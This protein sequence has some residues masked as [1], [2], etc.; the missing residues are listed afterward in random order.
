MFNCSTN[1][2]LVRVDVNRP[3]TSRLWL[4]RDPIGEREGV[5]LFSFVENCPISRE[6][7]FGLQSIGGTPPDPGRNCR[8]NCLNALTTCL[9]NLSSYWNSALKL[10]I[11]CLVAGG[12][13]PRSVGTSIM[14]TLTD[15]ESTCYGAYSGCLSSCPSYG[16]PVPP[17]G[18]GCSICPVNNPPVMYPH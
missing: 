13:N 5:N 10:G 17:P 15:V 18:S 8:N 14:T 9:N 6:D 4:N 1:H 3:S 11:R 2:T 7:P 16:Y 12:I